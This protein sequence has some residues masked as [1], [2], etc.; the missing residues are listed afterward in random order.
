MRPPTR[1]F[2]AR[3]SGRNGD[4]HFLRDWQSEAGVVQGIGEV[5]GAHEP[6]GRALGERALDG[7]V[8]VR[9]NEVA[10]SRNR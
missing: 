4:A 9:G 8:D 2:G 6:I 1:A 3:S 10:A 5:R 7:G